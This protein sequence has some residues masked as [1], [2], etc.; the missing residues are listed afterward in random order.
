MNEFQGGGMQLPLIGR[1]M[2]PS[3]Q[4]QVPDVV[5]WLQAF[6]DRAQH[7][8]EDALDCAVFADDALKLF[9]ERFQAK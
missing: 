2:V 4:P 5:I 1:P 9:K 6:H 7:E 8:R 3:A